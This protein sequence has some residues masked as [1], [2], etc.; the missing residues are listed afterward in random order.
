LRRIEILL[1]ALG[2]SPD[3]FERFL[4]WALCEHLVSV[5]EA[6]P[7]IDEGFFS[8]PDAL[9]TFRLLLNKRTG[10]SWSRDD[11]VQL[12]DRVK[13]EHTLQIRTSI[14]YEERMKLLSRAPLKC[15][16]CGAEPPDVDLHI[17]H[18]RPVSKGGRNDSDNLQ[19]LCA[20]HNLAKSNQM[21][22]SDSWLLLT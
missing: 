4:E 20:K 21:E 3:S 17:D 18:I 13:A 12:F 7:E 9:N 19:F 5:L 14:P 2:I 8:K 1:T 10:R 6:L 15:A 22:V 11:Y 16:Q